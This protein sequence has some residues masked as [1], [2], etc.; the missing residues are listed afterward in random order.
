MEIDEAPESSIGGS[1]VAFDDEAGRS[2]WG[3]M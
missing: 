3:E 2:A 1:L